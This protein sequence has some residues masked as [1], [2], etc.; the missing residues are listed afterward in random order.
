M[1]LCWKAWQTIP[2]IFESLSEMRLTR[3]ASISP[4]V[5]LAISSRD[6]KNHMF[7][8]N[9]LFH[10]NVNN[11]N[12]VNQLR[13]KRQRQAKIWFDEKQTY[14]TKPRAK[15]IKKD[16]VEVLEPKPADDPPAEPVQALLDA[17]IPTYTPPCTV[18]FVPIVQQWQEKNPFA[19]FMKFL[20]EASITAIVVATNTFAACNWEPDHGRA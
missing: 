13:P 16:P 12:M 15:R 1:R 18:P 2:M 10:T 14:N 3:K 17:P 19:L 8:P 20:T 4:A 11:N 7:S 9:C 6:R 5:S